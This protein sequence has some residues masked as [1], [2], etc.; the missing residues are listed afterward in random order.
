MTLLKKIYLSNSPTKA[1]SIY[2]DVS[3]YL[4]AKELNENFYDKKKSVKNA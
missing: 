3:N 4:K 1:H 2:N